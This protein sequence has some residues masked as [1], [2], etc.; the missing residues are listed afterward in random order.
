M[1]VAGG[2]RALDLLRGDRVPGGE[3]LHLEGK[4]RGLLPGAPGGGG[5][6]LGFGREVRHRRPRFIDLR[7]F[8]SG[9]LQE[10]RGV[11]APRRQPRKR[12]RQGRRGCVGRPP[13]GLAA[14]VEVGTERA[15]G[16]DGGDDRPQVAIR[17]IVGLARE[18]RGRPPPFV[19]LL[20]ALRDLGD[21]RP[22]LDVREREFAQPRAGDP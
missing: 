21:R 22:V 5:L 7:L 13:Q 14:G 9:E 6:P 10:R 4:G 8:D 19:E 3:L 1:F 12:L 15:R 20:L 2:A 16:V 17:L 11:A 18:T